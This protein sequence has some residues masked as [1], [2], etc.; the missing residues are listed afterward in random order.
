MASGFTARRPWPPP[1]LEVRALQGSIDPRVFT[2][3]AAQP[4]VS[5]AS[6]VLEQGAA[7]LAH[8]RAVGET[9]RFARTRTAAPG[10]LNA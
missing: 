8:G 6:P 1:D 9:R 10:L 3:L 7:L 2:Q 4:Q 5:L